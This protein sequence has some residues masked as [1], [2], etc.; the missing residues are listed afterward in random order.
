[1]L[2]KTA[3]YLVNG[4]NLIF[5][6]RN[7]CNYFQV[8]FDYLGWHFI[9]SEFLEHRFSFFICSSFYFDL[10][11]KYTLCNLRFTE[12]KYQ[13]RPI[14]P[15]D[16][17][18]I[19]TINYSTGKNCALFQRI[20]CVSLLS[21]DWPMSSPKMTHGQSKTVVNG[22]NWR[23][24]LYCIDI[25]HF[26]FLSFGLYN[27]Q[28]SNFKLFQKFDLEYITSKWRNYHWMWFYAWWLFTEWKTIIITFKYTI[29]NNIYKVQ[30]Y[31]KL[32]LELTSL[33]LR[34]LY[35]NS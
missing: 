8:T 17:L 29:H 5:K 32:T 27:Q 2:S 16:K 3:V 18:E 35:K 14:W 20:E 4:Y 19:K 31:T 11:P 21:V 6:L 9:L 26:V 30:L 12:W 24:R 33:I 13:E 22:V 34:V 10:P 1:M 25:I 15:G 7:K 23:W 28:K